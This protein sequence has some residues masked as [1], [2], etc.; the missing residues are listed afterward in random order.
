MK[1]F[2]KINIFIILSFC[3]FLVGCSNGKKAFEEDYQMF[4]G[5]N[6]VYEKSNYDEVYNALTK[7]EGYQIILFAYD[8]NLAICPYCIKIL[9]IINDL[10]L[11]VGIKK[12]L[13]LD[14]RT[15]RVERTLE[16][17]ALI[18]YISEQF[19]DLEMKNDQIEIIVPDL[20][21]VKDGKILG[22]HIATLKN[23]EGKYILDLNEEEL[24]DLTTIY[25][26]L[27]KQAKP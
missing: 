11:E 18:E 5:I 8:P 6:H 16:Y 25:Y 20:Y 15:M 4:K 22:H 27:L 13:Y 23:E 17:L 10:A 26:N 7:K 19:S 14:I 12:I 21:I 1:S 2:Y 3:L 24:K 9:P